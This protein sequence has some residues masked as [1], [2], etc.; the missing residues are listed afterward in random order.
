MRT[1]PIL[2]RRGVGL[3]LVGVVLVLVAQ[4]LGLGGPPVYDGLPVPADPYRYVDPPPGAKSTPAPLSAHARV[5]LV[6]G[7]ISPIDVPTGEFPPQAELWLYHGDV[8]GN[9]P[10]VPAVT[11]AQVTITPV[12]PPSVA[13]PPGRQLHG[14]VYEMKVV[15][16][17]VSLAMNPGTHSMVALRQPRTSAA[18]PQIAVLVRS[19][20]QLLDSHPTAG[21]GVLGARLPQLGAVA[22]LERTSG[23]V[24][25][26][27]HS[28]WWW[29]VLGVALLVVAAVIVVVR[30]SRTRSIAP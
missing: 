21:S 29:L 5:D 13:F 8:N 3:L 27:G 2:A 17:G 25:P 12:Q 11:T 24:A 4:V 20:W 14:N 6:G 7:G 10:D 15:A 18:D 26:Q 22:I 1:P 23:F 30:I 28:W 9:L 16:D 19:Q